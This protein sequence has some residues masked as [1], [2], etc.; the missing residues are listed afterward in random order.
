MNGGISYGRIKLCEDLVREGDEKQ[1]YS[2]EIG[3]GL[4]YRK[5]QT[6]K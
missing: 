4:C 2:L 3:S 5:F 6:K 1:Q